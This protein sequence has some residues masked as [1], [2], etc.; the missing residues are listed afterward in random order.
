M[1]WDAPTFEAVNK[2]S[3]EPEVMAWGAFHNTE[4]HPVMTIEESAKLFLK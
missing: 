3:M 1:V 2:F 4:V